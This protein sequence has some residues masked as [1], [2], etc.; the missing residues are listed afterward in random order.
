M[1]EYAPLTAETV[2][3]ATRK[4]HYQTADQ[5]EAEGEKVVA[6]AQRLHADTDKYIDD[7]SRSLRAE[8]QRAIEAANGARDLLKSAAAAA[9]ANGDEIVE[10][11]R[12][13]LD[14][15]AQAREIAKQVAEHY[16]K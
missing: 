1:N 7:L 6:N 3:D 13:S 4:H 9:R 2:A 5:L 11:V 8:V 10:R 15:S 12:E 16:G 14:K